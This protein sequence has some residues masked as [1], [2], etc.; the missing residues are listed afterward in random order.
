MVAN[1]A[2]YLYRDLAK[3]SYGG[4]VYCL[5][6]FLRKNGYMTE[7]PSAFYGEKT[8][9]AVVA[10]QARHG[11]NEPRKG[12][13]GR[14][15]RRLFA[16]KNGLP[17]PEEIETE[18]KELKGANGRKLCMDACAMFNEEKYCHTRCVRQEKNKV[19]ACREACQIA[20]AEACDRQHPGEA[21]AA[22]YQECLAHSASQ[23][24][25]LCA[26]HD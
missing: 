5:Q 4:D 18:N 22:Q 24:T 11:I 26:Q 15:T 2:C 8:T 23:C 21:R 10:Y 25:K 19:H 7:K 16:R 1:D 20:F 14:A 12:V 13:V 3:G 6:E 9:E 17:T